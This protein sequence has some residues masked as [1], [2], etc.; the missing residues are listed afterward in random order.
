MRTVTVT[1][2]VDPEGHSDTDIAEAVEVRLDEFYPSTD[3]PLVPAGP[4]AVTVRPKGSLRVT[5]DMDLTGTAT[6]EEVVR[7]LGAIASQV[8]DDEDGI[9]RSVSMDAP[10]PAWQEVN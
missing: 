3:H 4:V 6:N 10:H 9:V 2:T 8:E 7:L 1:M 5:I